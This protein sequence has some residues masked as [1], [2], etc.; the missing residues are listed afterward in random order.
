MK[1]NNIYLP[2]FVP[3]IEFETKLKKILDKNELGELNKLDYHRFF[4]SPDFF[5]LLNLE[6]QTLSNG[7]SV[8]LFCYSLGSNLGLILANKYHNIENLILMSTPLEPFHFTQ[9]IK[10]FGKLITNHADFDIDGYSNE[11]AQ[12]KTI[13]ISKGITLNRIIIYG[14]S[15]LLAKESLRFINTPTLIIVGNKDSLV[16]PNGSEIVYN[17]LNENVNLI[18]VDNGRHP[19]LLSSKSDIIATEIE[20]FI[21]NEKCLKKRKV[22]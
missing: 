3:N 4:D 10:D 13:E 12:K 17:S 2:P 22:I 14:K 21:T 20:Q 9:N 19:V 1:V 8:N 6:F 7:N 18:E 5:S 11:Y 16:S 15:I